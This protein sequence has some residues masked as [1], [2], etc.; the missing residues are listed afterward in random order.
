MTKLKTA[1][2]VNAIAQLDMSQTYNYY[3]GATKI[4]ITEILKPEGAINFLRWSSRESPDK[5]K[6]GTVSTG[7][8]GTVASVFSGKPNYPIHLARLFSA[9]G[10]S[11]SSIIVE[12]MKL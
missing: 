2:L 7:Q 11:R 3:S 1:D 4:K 12:E 10:N 5:A 6:R 9:G 8:L